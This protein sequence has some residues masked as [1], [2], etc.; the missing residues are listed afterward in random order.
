MAAGTDHV[1]VQ[2]VEPVVEQRQVTETGS[3][4]AQLL[5]GDVVARL[6]MDA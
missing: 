1:V 4:L 3:D 2:A 6:T 5:D